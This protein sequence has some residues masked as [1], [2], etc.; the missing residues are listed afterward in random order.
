MWC[1]RSVCSSGVCLRVC[2]C[3]RLLFRFFSVNSEL[4][5]SKVSVTGSVCV[6]SSQSLVMHKF[7][8]FDSPEWVVSL[9]DTFHFLLVVIETAAKAL[10]S[11]STYTH[12]Q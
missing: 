10:V 1:H 12:V 5:H 11:S 8:A 9:C 6:V 4:I 2:V 3:G 7:S